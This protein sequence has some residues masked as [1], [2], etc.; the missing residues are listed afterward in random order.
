MRLLKQEGEDALEFL[1]GFIFAGQ[2]YIIPQIVLNFD[3][4]ENT[5]FPMYVSTNLNEQSVE[6]YHIS[7]NKKLTQ[8]FKNKIKVYKLVHMS[9]PTK[10]HFI[11]IGYYGEKWYAST[12]HK[13][14]NMDYLAH[15][16]LLP[17]LMMHELN[18]FRDLAKPQNFNQSVFK[19]T[20]QMD[21]DF[22]T[23]FFLYLKT[24]FNALT[25]FKGTNYVCNEIFDGVRES[26]INLSNISKY[27]ES[28]QASTNSEIGAYVNNFPDKSHYVILCT[29][30]NC[31]F[32]YVSFYGEFPGKVKLTDNY[33]GE[34]FKEGLICDWQNRK[35]FRLERFQ[36]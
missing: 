34:E 32:A 5:V 19:Y 28:D 12:S 11:V 2:S 35:E 20:D 29:K 3:D 27:I 33:Q 26:I 1:L 17:M 10:K 8:F 9:Y 36:T 16:L 21:T 22:N 6:H 13:T 25:F 7:L 18:H 14:I 15:E 24:A 23:F 31:L 4:E 30:D